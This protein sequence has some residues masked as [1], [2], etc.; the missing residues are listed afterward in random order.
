MRTTISD[1]HS[2][3]SLSGRWLKLDP[4]WGTPVRAWA[5]FVE[6]SDG[7]TLDPEL[8]QRVDVEKAGLVPLQS[9]EF[10]DEEL[11]A[12]KKHFSRLK[13]HHFDRV[14][15]EVIP[16]GQ[17]QARRLWLTDRDI[18]GDLADE[19]PEPAPESFQL[20]RGFTTTLPDSLAQQ[21]DGL[22]LKQIE[23][24]PAIK[25]ESLPQSL[26]SDQSL[27]EMF[28]ELL[29][30]DA[31]SIRKR[32]LPNIV[33]LATDIISTVDES[34][35]AETLPV[36][37]RD[38]LIRTLYRKGRALGYMELPDV[39]AEQPIQDQRTLDQ[40]FEATFQRLSQIVDITQPDFILLAIRRQRRRRNY[41]LALDLVDLYRKQQPNPVWF[42]KK[43][44]DLLTEMGAP[45]SAHQASIDLWLHGS[46][47]KKPVPVTLRMPAV[48]DNPN[49]SITFVGYGQEPWQPMEMTFLAQSD[50][51]LETVIWL[52]PGTTF[53]VTPMHESSTG[54]FQ[55]LL[56]PPDSRTQRKPRSQYSN[57]EPHP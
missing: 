24:L 39:V 4:K 34:G 25:P 44:R 54:A 11:L 41:G 57:D 28:A 1:N 16:R 35:D 46:M 38:I 18:D 42:Q 32:H 23:S 15:V 12:R 29:K 10:T 51:S 21:S 22:V 17:Q 36:E 45:L 8:Q 37:T 27:N 6:Q 53:A 3:G 2:I 26:P 5:G 9:R 47:P 14:L 56:F 7:G 30:L 52:P 20:V 33:A 19:Q 48:P 49:D 40:E 43:R 50:R 55:F 31:P 13:I